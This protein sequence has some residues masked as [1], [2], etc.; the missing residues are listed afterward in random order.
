M[1]EPRRLA[2][3][4]VRRTASNPPNIRSQPA[5]CQLLTIIARPRVFAGQAPYRGCSESIGIIRGHEKDRHLIGFTAPAGPYRSA[6]VQPRESRQPGET[7]APPAAGRRT[8]PGIRIPP[9]LR[10][11][12]AAPVRRLAAPERSHRAAPAGSRPTRSC[13]G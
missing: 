8:A 1:V 12:T 2:L 10:M 6:P 7:P 3:E 5:I 4:D 13:R 11:Q 9:L